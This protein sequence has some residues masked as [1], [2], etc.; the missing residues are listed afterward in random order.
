[1][2]L[3]Y[4]IQ[5]FKKSRQ[6]GSTTSVSAGSK[7]WYLSSGRLYNRQKG[8]Q[9]RYEND[10]W[11]FE[12]YSGVKFYIKNLSK[13]QYL[14]KVGNEVILQDKKPGNDRQLWIKENL[15]HYP[16]WYFTLQNSGKNRN[17][18]LTKAANG[19]RLSS[20]NNF[21]IKLTNLKYVPFNLHI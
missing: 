18:A 14:A 9:Q 7:Q 20:K 1:M 8:W 15:N 3:I 10:Q 5:H 21:D 13:N 6:T 11:V 19:L 12:N 16:T 2:L 4:L 17:N